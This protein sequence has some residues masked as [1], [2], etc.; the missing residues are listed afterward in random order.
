MTEQRG[1]RAGANTAQIVEFFTSA[2]DQGRQVVDYFRQA[3]PAEAQAALAIAAAVVKG[4]TPQSESTAPRGRRRKA[5]DADNAGG[6]A[7]QQGAVNAAPA[8]ASG[9]QAGTT[10]VVGGT[11]TV[12]AGTRQGRVIGG[13]QQDANEGS[14][15]R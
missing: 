1:R 6:G 5:Q 2:S 12:A 15:D 13:P 10:R 7:P 4:R 14:S 11:A 3:D 9:Q 8:G